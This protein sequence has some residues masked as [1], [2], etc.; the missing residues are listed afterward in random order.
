MSCFIA[1]NIWVIY[2]DLIKNN[3]NFCFMYLF[4][5]IEFIFS[6]YIKVYQVFAK[7]DLN[8]YDITNPNH[9]DRMCFLMAFWC[10]TSIW[11]LITLFFSCCVCCCIFFIRLNR[12]SR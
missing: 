12:R 7:S 8:L 3:Y 2:N 11:I 10:I 1:G 5:A 6:L 4:M 9:C